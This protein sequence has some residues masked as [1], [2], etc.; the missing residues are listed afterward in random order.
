M[1]E[2]KKKAV[3]ASLKASVSEEFISKI[4]GWSIKEIQGVAR[5]INIILESVKDKCS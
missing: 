5:E 1:L 3:T 2:A 4:I